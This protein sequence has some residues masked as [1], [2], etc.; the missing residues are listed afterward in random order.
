MILPLDK[1]LSYSGNKYVLT[2]A[3]MMA[4]DKKDK[5][6][7]FPENIPAWKTVPAVM[8]LMFDGSIKINEKLVEKESE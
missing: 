5:I 6:D 4:V 1:L 7:N 3:A 8:K 2:K